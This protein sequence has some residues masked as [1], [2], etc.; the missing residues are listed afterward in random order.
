MKEAEKSKLELRS[1]LTHEQEIS[2][3]HSP[4]SRE[5]VQRTREIL[6]SLEKEAATEKKR[7]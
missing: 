2:L 7:P 3:T 4:L 1:E 5:V 6:D